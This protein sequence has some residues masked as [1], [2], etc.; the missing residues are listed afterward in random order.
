MTQDSVPTTLH[1]LPSALSGQRCRTPLDQWHKERGARFTECDGWRLPAAYSSLEEE[2]AC[3]RSRVGLVDVSAFAKIR[4]S[5]SAIPALTRRFSAD[6]PAVTPGS[7]F[8]MNL[9]ESPLGCM[10]ADDQLLVLGGTTDA[11]HLQDGLAR[12]AGDFPV[13]RHEVTSAL[14]GI[15]V[16]GPNSEDLLRRLTA[17]DLA[18][19]AFPAGSCAETNCAGIHGTVVR[20]PGWSVSAARVYVAWDLG[21]Y[22][23]QRLFDAG[24]HFGVMPVGIEAWRVLGGKP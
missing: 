5:G 4:L 23:W 6:G 14:A 17:F 19:S 18:H 20:D 15:H 8:A 13:E 21:E 3:A 7:V 10:L 11:A 2:L 9:E 16:I 1:S 24:R 22:L 12:L